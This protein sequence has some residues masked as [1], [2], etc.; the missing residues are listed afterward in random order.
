MNA[1]IMVETCRVCA[2]ET[3]PVLDLGQ[4]ALT[5]TFPRPSEV[6]PSGPLQLR[7]CP[8]CSLVQ[9]S[10]DYASDLMYGEN[11]G[12]RS[13]LNTSMVHHLAS[14]ADSTH[15]EGHA[16]QRMEQQATSQMVN[17]AIQQLASADAEI[18]TLFYLSEQTL[19][20]IGVAVG[21]TPNNVKVRLFR[22]RQKLREL[23]GNPW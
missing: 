4:Q 20:E 15:S 3:L 9:L 8:T 11:Y 23:V 18:V 22:A 1:F 7:W 17:R 13:G 14:V 21:M 6:V 2:A 16:G 10:A 5:G 19:E 12:Y